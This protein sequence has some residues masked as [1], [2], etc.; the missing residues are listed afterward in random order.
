MKKNKGLIKMVVVI[1]IALIVLGYFGFN[2]KDIIESDSVQ[3]NLQ[4]VW[5]FVKTFWNNYLAAPVI[6][7]WDKFV[8]GV[9]WRLIQEG[10]SAMNLG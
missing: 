8:V 5:G 6:F 3:T 1:V 4:Y 10:L 7:M 2:I 9:L